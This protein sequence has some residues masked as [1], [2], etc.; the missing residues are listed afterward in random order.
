MILDKIGIFLILVTSTSIFKT[1]TSTSVGST[2]KI[3]TT[4]NLTKSKTATSHVTATRVTVNT[5]WNGGDKC[6]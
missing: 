4:I 1:N 2:T 3:T 5:S 6:S